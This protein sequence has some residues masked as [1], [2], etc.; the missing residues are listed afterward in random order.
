MVYQKRWGRATMDHLKKLYRTADASK[1]G[2]F[3]ISGYWLFSEEEKTLV[4]AEEFE[5][6]RRLSAEELK[7]WPEYKA[8]V[9]FTTYMC[10][11]Y[12]YLPWLLNKFSVGN[13]KVIK[14][15]LDSI[16]ELYDTYDIVVNCAGIG[17]AALVGDSSLEPVRGQLFRIKAPWLKHF[18]I[19]DTGHLSTFPGMN[20]VAIG[21]TLDHGNWDANPDP[22]ESRRIWSQICAR[23]PS[24]KNAIIERETCGLRPSRA[25]VRLETELVPHLNKYVP[26][27]HNYGH[28]GAGICTGDVQ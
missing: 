27:I 18:H 2:V 3:P 17:A 4:G 21:G 25:Q 23:L 6:F 26:I 8:G 7:M 13:G 16:T 15:K 11:G 10:E 19:F 14:R 5:C 24:L 1:A 20:N 12:I 28:G 9:F 22:K